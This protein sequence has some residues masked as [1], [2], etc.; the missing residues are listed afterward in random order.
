MVTRVYLSQ[1]TSPADAYFWAVRNFGNET[2]R[3]TVGNWWHNGPEFFFEY[4]KDVAW[5]VLNFPATV[6]NC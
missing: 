2:N 3:V 4:E 1:G 5:F 6:S